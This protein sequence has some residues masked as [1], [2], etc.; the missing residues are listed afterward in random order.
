MS[1]SP[2]LANG[3][4]AKDEVREN[5]SRGVQEKPADT[6]SSS[7]DESTVQWRK[8][9]FQELL[10]LNKA[11]EDDGDI[12]DIQ[13]DA[14]PPKRR[15]SAGKAADTSRKPRSEVQEKY[16]DLEEAVAAPGPRRYGRGVARQTTA[17]QPEKRPR[18]KRE[19]K[20]KEPISSHS[21][22]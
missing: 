1:W 7:E 19:V 17:A 6:D 5:A 18:G 21:A 9:Q 13:L 22:R 2:Y 14:R 4:L 3:A 8:D 15:S 12:P 16:V 20:K 11:F 10:I